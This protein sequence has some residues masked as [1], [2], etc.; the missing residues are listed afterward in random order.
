[1][2]CMGVGSGNPMNLKQ[3]FG[4]NTHLQFSVALNFILNKI[5]VLF[6]QKLHNLWVSYLRKNI[7]CAPIKSVI[8]KSKNVLPKFDI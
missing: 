3:R 2:K 1:M 5:N 4:Q 6:P 8:I 7:Q